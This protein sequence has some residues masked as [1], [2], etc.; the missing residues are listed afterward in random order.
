MHGSKKVKKIVQNIQIKKKM[1]GA[2][3]AGATFLF[4]LFLELG[5]SDTNTK[6]QFCHINQKNITN[7]SS[8]PLAEGAT[9]INYIFYEY[10]IHLK[11]I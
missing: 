8:R 2:S 3:R 9:F 4:Y 10:Y 5:P 6:Y 11:K 7:I 1:S